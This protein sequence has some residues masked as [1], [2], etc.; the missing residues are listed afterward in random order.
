MNDPGPSSWNDLGNLYREKVML[1]TVGNVNDFVLLTIHLSGKLVMFR[2]AHKK[3][4]IIPDMPSP[5]DDVILY[6]GNF[7]AVDNTGRTV[8]VGLDLSV[9]LVAKPV[10][11]GD[12]K[13]LVESRDELLLV[14]MYLSIESN[15]DSTGL[16]EEYFENLSCYMNERTVRFKV[17]RL[18]EASQKWVGIKNLGDQV[19][20][21]G[22]DCTFSASAKDMHVSRG[23]CIIFVDNFFYLNEEEYGSLGNHGI[24]VF[25]LENDSIGPL[26]K[27]PPC[28]DLFWPPPQWISSMT[29]E[30]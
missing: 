25:D 20:F 13:F 11:G 14:D 22:D 7:Y 27:Y 6:K 1:L 4:T 26:V 8:L 5:Y 16:F 21:L 28:S 29:L 15:S 3:W 19:L 24:G 30:V 23:N 10:F 9:S 2:S 12:K 18:D 17:F